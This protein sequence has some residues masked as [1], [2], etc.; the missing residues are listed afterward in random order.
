[1]EDFKEWTNWLF[2]R[3]GIGVKGAESWEAWWEEELVRTNALQAVAV[4]F[5]EM[6]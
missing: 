3:G 5:L 2:Y 6:F 1:M 4:H